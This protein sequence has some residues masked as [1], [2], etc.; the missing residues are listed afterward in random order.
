MDEQPNAEVVEKVG[1]ESSSVTIDDKE[2]EP[3]ETK[4]EIPEPEKEEITE[5]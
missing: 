1:K 2:P 4:E 5:G 3:E